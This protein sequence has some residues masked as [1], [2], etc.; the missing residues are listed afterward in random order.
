M[1]WC[2]GNEKFLNVWKDP[3]LQCQENS[4]ITINTPHGYEGE[5]HL[6]LGCM[7]AKE[8]WDPSGL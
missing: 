7:K 8:I 5:L 1:R 6:F 2:I 3:C 4:Y